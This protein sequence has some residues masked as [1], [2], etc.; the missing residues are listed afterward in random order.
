MLSRGLSICSLVQSVFGSLQMASCLLANIEQ[1]FF[2]FF[3][4]LCFFFFFKKFFFFI[5]FSDF[6]T[7]DSEVFPLK[8]ISLLQLA[9]Y[10]FKGPIRVSFTSYSAKSFVG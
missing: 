5:C 2:L 4:F 3:S 8:E 7:I 1:F 10:R 6:L 9:C